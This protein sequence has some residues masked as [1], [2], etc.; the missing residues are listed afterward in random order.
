MARSVPYTIDGMIFRVAN[1]GV[2]KTC[3]G[4][5]KM[6]NK[7]VKARKEPGKKYITEEERYKI[8]KKLMQKRT[9]P[10]IA[11]ELDIKYNTLY[12]EIQRGKVIQR[13]HLWEDKLVYKADYA[14]MVY[15]L[16]VANRGRNLKI[17]AD[18]KLVEYIE[19]MIK[20]KY[21]PYA[22]L[23]Q[24]VKDGKEF[25]GKI[26][27]KTIYNLLDMGLFANISNKDLTSKKTDARKKK[28]RK[29]KV[30]LNNISGRSI[31]KRPKHVE[32]RLEYGHWEMDTVYSAKETGKACL[33]VLTERKD[34]DEI[35]I[36]LNSRKSLSVIRALDELEKRMGTRA[37]KRKFKTITCD[38]GT[39][40]LAS[41][42][43]E[44]SKYGKGKRTMLYY[45]HPFSSFERGSNE[46]ANR[47][48]R[49]FFPKGTN[50]DMVTKKQV[51]MV[52]DWINNYP[53]KIF[54][55][56]SANE[57]KLANKIAA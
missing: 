56:L 37:F 3:Q 24:A 30:A 4:G 36:K 17:G 55:G 2:S 38:N 6:K 31:E 1:F 25:A 9:I 46:N 10:Q 18:D 7:R 29:R 45:C 8:E 44:A 12:K 41:D 40:F 33:L 15:E 27:F 52:E 23:E 35:I 53:R 13:N 48:I 49:R 14:Q 28:E 19:T 11:D 21:S 32:E 42:K 47:L 54:G 5:Q 20:K 39:E 50:F 51:Q 26:C 34:R 57:M 22:L 43:I 16:N